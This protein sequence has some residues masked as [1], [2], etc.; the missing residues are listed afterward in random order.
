M[1]WLD[2]VEEH[3]YDAAYG[4]LTLLLDE[5]R[6]GRCIEALRQAEVTERR[7][8]DILRAT[9]YDPLPMDDPG[10]WRAHLKSQKHHPLSPVLV[11]SWEFGGDIADGYHRVCMAYNLDPF[12]MVPLRLAHV[13]GYE[14]LQELS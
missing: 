1:R 7:A 11:V 12:A 4:F 6:A 9:G 3:D 8:N 10:V 5:Y 2:D 14:R 13:P